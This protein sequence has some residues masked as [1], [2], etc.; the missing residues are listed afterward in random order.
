MKIFVFI[1]NNPPNSP[2]QEAKT[3]LALHRSERYHNNKGIQL[4]C[5]CAHVCVCVCVK[6]CACVCVGMC[7]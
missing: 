3:T 7:V 4:V 2:H 1:Q 5:V 6:L